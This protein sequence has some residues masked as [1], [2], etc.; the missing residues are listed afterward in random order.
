[1]AG[2]SIETMLGLWASSLSEVEVR[3]R[4]LFA[5]ERVEASTRP[6]S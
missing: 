2:A 3:M 6:V 5:Q 1:M 4:G